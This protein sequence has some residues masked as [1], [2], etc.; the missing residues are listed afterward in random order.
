MSLAAMAALPK[1]AEAVRFGVTTGASALC[2]LQ[3]GTSLISV[4]VSMS[5]NRLAL[6]LRTISLIFALL[7]SWMLRANPVD[8]A[9]KGT[10]GGAVQ[11]PTFLLHI[12]D[13]AD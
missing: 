10:P 7:L 1:A 9:G 12:G 11:S 3:S 4:N 6:M 5:N 2:L 8:G 13:L